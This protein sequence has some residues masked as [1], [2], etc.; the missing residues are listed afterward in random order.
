[1]N[2]QFRVFQRAGVFYR[3]DGATGRQI[4]LHTKDEAE[5]LTLL[6]A[7]TES[8][9]QPALNLQLAT[10]YLAVSDPLVTT[11]TWRNVMDEIIRTKTGAN[12]DR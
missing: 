8:G 11:R 4:S 2:Q 6:H 10:V 7:K 5:A 12:Q 3:A 1:M 9:R